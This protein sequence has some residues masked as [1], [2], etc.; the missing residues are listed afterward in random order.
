MSKRA[1]K[2]LRLKYNESDTHTKDTSQTTMTESD[3]DDD[4]D[5]LTNIRMNTTY[6]T[7]TVKLPKNS[8]FIKYLHAKY[9]TLI[10]ILL[11]ADDKLLINQYDPKHDY[12]NAKFIRNAKE[13]PNKMTALQ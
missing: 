12:V 5:S 9:T 3:D 6:C 10:D 2:R 8:D 11:Q 13:L 4:N 7:V 1:S